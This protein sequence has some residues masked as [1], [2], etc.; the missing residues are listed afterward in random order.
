LLDDDYH[1]PMG[2]AQKLTDP[3][4]DADPELC[5]IPAHMTKTM[6]CYLVPV[7]KIPNEFIAEKA[8]LGWYN[9]HGLL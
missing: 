7:H 9:G 3:D 1:I 8:Y 4:P 5:Y 2:E 6:L